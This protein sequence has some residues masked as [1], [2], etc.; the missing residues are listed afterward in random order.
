M[1]RL[2]VIE[3]DAKGQT[4][5]LSNGITF[6]GRST[7][8]D[9][10]VR[11]SSISRKHLKI[12]HI[13]KKIFLEDLKSTNGTFINSNKIVPGEGFEVSDGDLITIGKTVL[14]LE[15]L[16]EP[17]KS[18]KAAKPEQKPLENHKAPPSQKQ[19]ERRKRTARELKLINKVSRLLKQSFS[20]YGFSEK[21]LEYLL[22][23]LPRIDTAAIVIL[24]YRKSK[25]G[26]ERTIVVKSRPWL[27]RRD[28]DFFEQ[29][30][31]RVLEKKGPVRMSN[32][33]YEEL[34]D[35]KESVETLKIG[36]VLCVPVISNSVIRGALYV[37][38]IG[39]PYG[40]RKE[41]LL[42]LNSLS[43]SIAVAFEKAML[44]E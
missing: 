37:D 30:I 42:L 18:T 41:D 26:K 9:I 7:R 34:G 5:D 36:S 28:A 33:A 1:P 19:T 38:S 40:F 15:A 31:D 10:R 4:F 23:G 14:R 27:E 32:T 29:I 17:G 11:D 44:T 12:F 3:G 22:Q 35:L 39:D 25:R 21:V 2:V 24:D 6:I 16:H 8:S 20:L 13:G 43:G